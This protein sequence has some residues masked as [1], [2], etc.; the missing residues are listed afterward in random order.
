LQ[1]YLDGIVKK[2]ELTR[3]DKENDRVRHIETLNSQS[4]PVF[5]TYRAVKEVDDLFAKHT[6]TTPEIDFTAPDGVRHSSWTI[7][8][9]GEIAFIRNAFR[10]H[11]GAF[12]LRMV[13]IEARRRRGYSRHA[14]GRKQRT[15]SGG[16]FPA[17]ADGDFALQP[18]SQDLNGIRRAVAQKLDAVFVIS[19]A[20][21]A[22]P[23]RRHEVC[24][25]LGGKWRMMAF[26]SVRRDEGSDREARCHVAAEI[27]PGP[28]FWHRRSP[29]ERTD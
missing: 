26:A 6:S 7:S 2:H 22:Q 13:T 23:T 14:R 21:W 29:D 9:P 28:D 4:G 15:F 10:E 1:E 25:Y 20:S 12:T 3:P 8:A 11:P 16:Y 17:F 5:L 19:N 18:C 24:L 27:R